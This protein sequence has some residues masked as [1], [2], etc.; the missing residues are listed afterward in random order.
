MSDRV[1]TSAGLLVR[2]PDGVPNRPK[3]TR[4]RAKVKLVGSGRG[5][6][7]Q[8]NGRQG[9][10]SCGKRKNAAQIPG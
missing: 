7:G 8:S 10:G 4:S 3:P 2:F 6:A 5:K 9:I 1:L